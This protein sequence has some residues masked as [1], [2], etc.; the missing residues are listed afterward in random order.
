MEEI[1]VPG[2][3]D[4]FRVN[5]DYFEASQENWKP[6]PWHKF[7]KWL[8]AHAENRIPA[9]LLRRLYE[10]SEPVPANFRRTSI[11]IPIPPKQ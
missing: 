1:S 2:Q 6:Q 11:E 4:T 3:A 5:L 7:F 10:L 9:S 8:A